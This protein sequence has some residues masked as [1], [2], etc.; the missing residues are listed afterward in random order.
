MPTLPLIATVASRGQTRESRHLY[1][2]AAAGCQ[3]DAYPVR[4]QSWPHPPRPPHATSAWAGPKRLV[5]GLRCGPFSSRARG[6][7]CGSGEAE[8]PVPAA[9]PVGRAERSPPRPQP[10]LGVG[11]SGD[12]PLGLPAPCSK[13]VASGCGFHALVGSFPVE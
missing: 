10:A 2:Q 4:R 5:A 9:D 11:R 13:H 7:P 3:S 12:S 1:P 8:S 6:R